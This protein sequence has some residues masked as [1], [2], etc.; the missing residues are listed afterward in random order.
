MQ[1]F[2]ADFGRGL[3]R[4]FALTGRSDAPALNFMAANG[5]PVGSYRFLLEGLAARYPLTAL[6]N[7]GAWPGTDAPK[8]G[9]GWAQHADDLIAFLES[10]HPEPVVGVGHSIG[11]TVSV[12]A[13][14]RRP[15]LFRALVLIDP[16]TIPGRWLPLAMKLLPFMASRI[17]LV[18]RTRGRRVHWPDREEFARYHHA[19]AVYRR[20]TPEAMR[21]YAQ[22][23][24]RENGEGFELAFRREWEAWNFQHT[25]SL[26]PALRKLELPVLL[27]RAEHS[28]LHPEA[29]FQ[30][31][32]RRAPANITAVTV[33]DAGH[34]LPQEAPAAVL[35]EIE[36]WLDRTIQAD[37]AVA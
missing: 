23:G 17:D 36:R 34:M 32:C 1:Q 31:Y 16:A 14:L 37:L 35:Q 8:K 9:F 28:Y 24:L 13:A 20:F 11:A 15:H 30:T 19:K 27:L 21:D 25:A 5:F 7:R 33:P 4:W 26:W 22:A 2:E 29:E 18:T 3:A 10:Q 12:L 6:E